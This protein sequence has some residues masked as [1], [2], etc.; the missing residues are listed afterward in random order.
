M[1]DFGSILIIKKSNGSLSNDDK[2]KITKELGKLVKDSEYSFMIQEGNHTSFYEMEEG[3]ECIRLSE[4]Y[5]DE[6]MTEEMIDFA[7]E[8]DL[9]DAQDIAQK[10]QTKLGSTFT[11]MGDFIDW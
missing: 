10:L 7:R 9:F 6:E 5:A 3:I 1:S 4:Y 2:Q 8:E 11:I